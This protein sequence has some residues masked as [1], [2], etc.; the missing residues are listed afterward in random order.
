ME[1]L[2]NYTKCKKCYDISLLHKYPICVRCISTLITS[3][4]TRYE[5]PDLPI[6]YNDNPFIG[7]CSICFDSVGVILCSISL[8]VGHAIE[9]IEP[10]G[11]INNTKYVI[12]PPQKL[13]I[14]IEKSSKKSWADVTDSNTDD[15]NEKII[16]PIPLPLI[17]QQQQP[18]SKIESKCARCNKYG[19][20]AKNCRVDISKTCRSCGEKGHYNTVCGLV[21]NLCKKKGHDSARCNI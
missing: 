6:F 19:H 17:Q 20:Y 9:L 12:H 18:E 1:C 2:L 15:E 8:C 11:S 21:C 10:I 3:N 16:Q 13:S 5:K 7:S 14:F 4:P